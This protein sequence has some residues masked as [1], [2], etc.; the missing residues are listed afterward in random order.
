MVKLL[1]DS[2]L[3]ILWNETIMLTVLFEAAV[4]LSPQNVRCFLHEN[5]E[6]TRALPGLL[7]QH[8]MAFVQVASVGKST[9]TDS[10]EYFLICSMSVHYII[11]KH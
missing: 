10:G 1:E 3:H 11:Q 8:D 9:Q 4:L 6:I 5:T 2:K 7:S